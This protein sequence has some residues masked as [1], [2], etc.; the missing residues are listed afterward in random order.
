MKKIV[1]WLN[2]L[3]ILREQTRICRICFGEIHDD[4]YFFVGKRN[5]QICEK[6]WAK[7]RP[8]FISFKYNNINALS[9]YNYDETIKNLLYQFK[10]CFDI[11]LAPIFLEKFSRELHLKYEKFIIVPIPSHFEDDKLRGFNHVEKIFESLNLPFE[12]LL[13]KTERIKQSDRSAGD[14]GK[15]S[16]ILALKQQVSLE[17]KNILLVDD[18]FT[19]GSTMKAAINLIEQLHPKKIEILVLSKTVFA[20]T[21][22]PN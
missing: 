6:C 21:N 13:Q 8:I 3:K 14:R 7:F 10:G 18:V 5:P 2:P 12:F 17:G 4:F 19:T 9:I 1:Q 16:E 11:E 22:S 20:T 15:I